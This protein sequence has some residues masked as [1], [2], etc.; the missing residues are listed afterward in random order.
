MTLFR[1]ADHVDLSTDPTLFLP[2]A[3]G[4]QTSVLP[5]RLGLSPLMGRDAQGNL[6][7]M[8]PIHNTF[9][10]GSMPMHPMQSMAGGGPWSP[11]SIK[12]R[13]WRPLPHYLKCVFRQ[14][15]VCDH[16]AFQ[17]MRWPASQGNNNPRPPSTTQLSHNSIPNG[18]NGVARPAIAMPYVDLVKPTEPMINDDSSLPPSM[19]SNEVGLSQSQDISMGINGAGPADSG[20]LECANEC[21]HLTQ[22]YD[23]WPLSL[24]WYSSPSGSRRHTETQARHSPLPSRC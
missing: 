11:C 13:R 3:S 19:Q 1:E 8:H 10:P 6:R 20:G 9:I 24:P 21:Y 4:Y 16:P 5:Y 15:A 7:P 23:V 14:T 18:I 17:R 12:S 22:P 2:T